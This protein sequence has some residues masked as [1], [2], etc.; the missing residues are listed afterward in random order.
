MG[1]GYSDFNSARRMLD[2]LSFDQNARV[3]K[4]KTMYKVVHRLVPQYIKDRFRLRVNTLPDTS[5]R[6]VLNQNLY[7]STNQ[8]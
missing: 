6:S 7:I 2:I 4:A 5:L 1:T 8:T 3:N